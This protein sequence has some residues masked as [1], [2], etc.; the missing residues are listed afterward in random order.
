MFTELGSHHEDNRTM[1][2]HTQF[3]LFCN[4]FLIQLRMDIVI[5]D[6]YD[7]NERKLAQQVIWRFF[8]KTIWQH[9]SEFPSDF[10]DLSPDFFSIFASQHRYY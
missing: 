1:D 6:N 2:N 10:Y 4:N 5:L 7:G 3:K 9:W 8:T